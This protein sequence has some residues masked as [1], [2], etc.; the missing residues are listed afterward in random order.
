MSTFSG[1]YRSCKP[2][3]SNPRP[4]RMHEILDMDAFQPFEFEGERYYLDEAGFVRH[5]RMEWADDEA[6]M[7]KPLENAHIL[8]AILNQPSSVR[9]S[10]VVDHVG[11][12]KHLKALGM[13]YALRAS[14]GEFYFFQTHASGSKLDELFDR[15]ANVLKSACD[16][17]VPGDSSM[18]RDLS[19]IMRGVPT[20]D[21]AWDG[22]AFAY[23]IDI[24]EYLRTYGDDKPFYE[25]AV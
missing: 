20:A 17:H 3:L 24:E 9:R 13:R 14:P 23:A 12:M 10:R 15:P 5:R 7:I 22:G 4:T 1:S 11:I 21:L 8:T 6:D 25:W 19:T 16:L 18:K 2:S